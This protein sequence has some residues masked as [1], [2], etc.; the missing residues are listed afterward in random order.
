MATITFGSN[1]VTN[2][3]TG[4]DSLIG[5]E[6]TGNTNDIVYGHQGDD[7]ITFTDSVSNSTLYGGQGN[8][9][10]EAFDGGRNIVYG[11]FGDDTLSSFDDTGDTLYGGQGND[12]I[13]STFG[14]TGA[15]YGNLGDDTI[16][17]FSSTFMKDRKSVV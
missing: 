1:S 2:G 16:S 4:N 17:V 6:P 14:F 5:N 8:D 3:T 10:F 13:A 9:L 7:T 11:N 15:V 12:V